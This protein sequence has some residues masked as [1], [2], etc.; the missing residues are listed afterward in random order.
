[1]E[2]VNI[3]CMKWGAKYPAEY[4]NKLH[5]MVARNLSRPHRFICLTDD[6]EGLNA[7]IETFPIPPMPVDTSQGPERCWTKI[8]T[9]SDSLYDIKGQCLYLDL[10]IVIIDKIDELFALEGEVIIIKD[11]SKTDGTG[12][13]SVYRFEMGRHSDVLQ[14]FV[15]RW[16]EVSREHRNEQEYI[17]AALLRKGAL[18][19][20][21]EK[22]CRSFKRHSCHPFPKSLVMM[23]RIPEGVKIIVFHGHPHP[24]EAIVGRSGFWYR[25]VRPTTWINDYWH[26]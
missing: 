3:L 7:Q 17:S 18:S 8:L 6:A 22:W 16:P 2:Q 13:S 5:G 4:V 1:M 11:W 14:E 12:N 10:D 21:P 26:S 25:F 23:P 15:D 24:D 19:Y 20:W 9:F